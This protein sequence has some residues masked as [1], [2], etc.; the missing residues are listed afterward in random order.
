MYNA[1]MTDRQRFI[2]IMTIAIGAL[3]LGGCM[4]LGHVEEK[5]SYGLTGILML[6]SQI[7]AIVGKSDKPKG[8]DD[9]KV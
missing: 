2:V 5:T 7:V 4:A 8:P 3:T 1:A 6:V 9:P